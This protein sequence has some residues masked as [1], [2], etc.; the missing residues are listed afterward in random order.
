[1][2]NDDGADDAI[3]HHGSP[4]Q[5]SMTSQVSHIFVLRRRKFPTMCKVVQRQQT[6]S[7]NTSRYSGVMTSSPV[8]M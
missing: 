8:Y 2:N 7:S 6:T 1:M 5:D 4:T 3:K